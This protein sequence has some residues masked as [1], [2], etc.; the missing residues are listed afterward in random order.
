M[1]VQNP[2]MV[3]KDKPQ[4]VS[5]KHFIQGPMYHIE[6]IKPF[7]CI[8]NEV[9]KGGGAYMSLCAE[10]IETQKLHV[11]EIQEGQLIIVDLPVKT[12][13][14]AWR[15]VNRVVRAQTTPEDSIRILFVKKSKQDLDI[16]EVENKV[17]SPE[18]EQFAKQEYK[19]LEKLKEE[20]NGSKIKTKTIRRGV[21]L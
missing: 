14:R 8:I 4:Q 17:M 19:E 15:C 9:H 2:F 5:W 10:V 11:S 13:D 12:F 6:L 18:Q 7:D 21:S 1:T 3:N 20:M 16:K